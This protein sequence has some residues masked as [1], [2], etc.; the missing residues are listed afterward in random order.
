MEEK[1]RPLGLKDLTIKLE[2]PADCPAI[3]N[4]ITAAFKGVSGATG[5]EANLVERLR[6]SPEYV[7]HLSLIAC[8]NGKII[9]HIMFTRVYI[10][11]AW[12]S[13]AL[14]PL[15][16]LPEYQRRGVGALLVEEGHRLAL[17]LGFVASVVMG[18]AEYY[19]RFGYRPLSEFSC[20]VPFNI[21][22]ECALAKELVPGALQ[23]VRGEAVF[24]A[25]FTS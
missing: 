19:P 18:C 17:E 2:S 13:L 21:A 24:S 8:L 7:P 25:A 16:V 23:Q 10:E 3:R 14:S 1:A 9:A 11:G 15:A 22:P 5:D 6:T 12:Q 20:T 4:V